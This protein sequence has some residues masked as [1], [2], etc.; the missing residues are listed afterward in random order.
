MQTTITI[1]DELTQQALE[2]LASADPPKD[3]AELFREALRT[4]VR[5]QAAK[6]L[7]ALDA[8]VRG[9]PEVPLR[10]TSAKR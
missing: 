8:P 1:D 3:E 9:L 4:F 10:V 2:A 6:R 7:A 5:I